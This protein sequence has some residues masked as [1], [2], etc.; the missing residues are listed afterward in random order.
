MSINL[1]NN[2]II[3]EGHYNSLSLIIFDKTK[4][5]KVKNYNFPNAINNKDF[6]FNS[7]KDFLGTRENFE[8]IYYGMG[9][10]SFTNIRRILSFVKAISTVRNKNFLSA[11]NIIG[12]NNL[13]ILG[14]YYLKNYPLNNRDFILPIFENSKSLIT[15][16]YKINHEINFPLEKASDIEIMFEEDIYSFLK[17]KNVKIENTNII[18][19]SKNENFL[20]KKQKIKS[21]SKLYL[22]K[23]LYQIV[24]I[25][26]NRIIKFEKYKDIFQNDLK[27]LYAKEPNT[28]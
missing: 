10:G 28:N 21:F 26:D 9:P 18:C 8:T 22:G 20:I 25:I 1:K 5:I 3:V 4:M 14:F 12:V 13:A 24:N 7:I 23:T 2:L 16:L 6:F 17:R 27:P 15:Q 11:N 19:I